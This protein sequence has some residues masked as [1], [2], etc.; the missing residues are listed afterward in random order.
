[1]VVFAKGYGAEHVLEDNVYNFTNASDLGSGCVDIW[2]AGALVFRYN[3][4]TNCLVTAH[5]VTHGTTVNFELY[6]NTLKRTANSGDWTDGTRLFHHQGSGEMLLWGNT[7]VAASSLSG[8]ALSITHYRSATPAVA[9]YSTSLGR[10][11]GTQARDGNRAAF[12]YP[13]WLQPGRAP[14]G[15]S[16]V[17]GTLSPIYAWMN[18]NQ[19]SGK[20][21][22]SIDNPWGAT[23]PSVSDH[24]KPDRDYYDAASASAQTSP[25]SPFNG[26]TGMGFGTLA[27]RPTTCTT[28]SLESGGGV[29][30][31]ATDTKTLYR[32][33]ATNT[34]TDH[35][36]PYAYPHPLTQSGGS[37]SGSG[38]GDSALLAPSNLR[39]VQ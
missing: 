26:T 19:S 22:V 20:V 12:G 30:Y 28:N 31:W 14:S 25:S 10:C 11:D 7:F 5:G 36:K 16:P 15:G 9:G 13:C 32:C 1:M 33:S 34:W 39:I 37:G 29:G 8:S 4:V 18:V 2:E 21:A 27:N 3:N 23:N 17:Y 38:S 35:Y 6:G 24:I